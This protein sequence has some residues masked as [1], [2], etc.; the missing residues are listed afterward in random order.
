MIYFMSLK[1]TVIVDRIKINPDA[2]STVIIKETGTNKRETLGS[3]PI[4]IRIINR[5]HI[6]KNILIKLEIID[7]SGNIILGK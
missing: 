6:E 2:I 4:N 5:A 3:Y 1:N 7:D